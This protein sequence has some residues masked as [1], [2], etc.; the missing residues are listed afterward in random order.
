MV[1]LGD[2]ALLRDSIECPPRL[3]HRRKNG[4]SLSVCFSVLGHQ[5][6][7]HMRTALL[8]PLKKRRD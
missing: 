5:L 2:H 7:D 6:L 3:T 1:S 4:V 8:T